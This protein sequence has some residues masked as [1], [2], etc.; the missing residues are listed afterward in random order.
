MRVTR[1][2]N[3]LL[4]VLATQSD[5]VTKLGLQKRLFFL[6]EKEK[7]AGL[8]STYDFYP[9]HRGCFSF[10]AD[11]DFEKLREESYIC[12]EN[13]RY[14]FNTSLPLPDLPWADQRRIAQIAQETAG[15]TD[16]ELALRVYK[17]HPFY[18]INSQWAA[19]LLAGN[20]EA[21]RCIEENRPKCAK[22]GALFTI[23]Y[24]GLSIE[25]FFGSLLKKGVTTLCDV[26]RVPFSH[27]QGFSK[28][29][30]ADLCH[31]M[32]FRYQHLPELGIASNRRK[33]LET[34][35]DYDLLFDEYRQHD[36]PGMEPVLQRLVEQMEKGGRIA[37]MCFE[38]NIRQCHRRLLAERLEQISRFHA[39]ELTDSKPFT[40]CQLLFAC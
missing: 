18:A 31:A 11:Y 26:R 32:D 8:A 30:L 24:E 7:K 20:T 35:E 27:K 13:G 21:L 36:L 1:K 14:E 12:K 22:E 34:Q 37:L 25:K 10:T 5:G 23:G 17:E 9:H 39:T 28:H 3:V 29:Q 16:E 19:Q 4:R 38:A 2:Q 6:A 40:P 33:K 15:A